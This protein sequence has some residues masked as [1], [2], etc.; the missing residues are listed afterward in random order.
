MLD[1]RNTEV[2]NY[3]PTVPYEDEVL[4][5]IAHLTGKIGSAD[6]DEIASTA[7]DISK[8]EQCFDA[9]VKDREWNITELAKTVQ[10]D[11]GIQETRN[12]LARKLDEQES[13][14]KEEKQELDPDAID[15]FIAEFGG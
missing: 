6:A 5:I 4:D 14:A 2:D 3:D 10:R 1:R 15:V 12:R 8:I 7:D 13:K 9:L 11:L